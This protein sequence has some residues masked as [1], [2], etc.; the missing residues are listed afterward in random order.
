MKKN[1][2]KFAFTALMFGMFFS[3][4]T[5]TAKATSD[6]EIDDSNNI[7]ISSEDASNDG[8]TAMQ[9]SLKITPKDE[10]GLTNVSFEFN[11]DNDVKVAEYRYHRDTNTLNVYMADSA[12]LFD[13]DSDTL[14]I[15]NVSAKDSTGKEVTIRIDVDADSLTM[16]SQNTAKQRTFSLD[17]ATQ[18]NL[19]SD[20]FVKIEKTFPSSYRIQIPSGT[21]ELT[22]GKQFN[23]LASDVMIEHDETL[24]VSVESENSW[25]LKDADGNDQTCIGYTMGYGSDNTAIKGKSADI[26]EVPAGALSGE[27]DIT[28]ISIDSPTT[29]GT[30]SD[31]LTFNVSVDSE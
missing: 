4:N 16:V 27:T 9:F 8:I 17:N 30:F 2:I 22:K 12:P 20:K 6:I 3:V 18:D 25:K 14:D 21:E 29:A 26:L 24:K 5:V 1:L 19:S 11:E 15:G 13:S 10:N 31:T 23:V 28:V 7:S